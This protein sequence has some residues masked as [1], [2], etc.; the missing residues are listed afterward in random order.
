VLEVVDPGLLLT[1]QDR[2]RSGW[3]HLGIPVSGAADAWG[4]VAA[5]LLAG[6]PAEAAALEVTLGGAELIARE[7]CLIALGGADLGAERDDGLALSVGA[8]HR[9]PVGARLRFAGSR[10]GLRAYLALSGGVAANRVLGSA[11]TYATAALGGVDGRALSAGDV[12]TPMRRGDLAAA[13]ISWP[14][15]APPHPATAPGPILFVPGPD[16]RHLDVGVVGAFTAAT[17]RIGRTGDRMG[18]RLEGPPLAAGTEIVSHA[19]VPG[20]IQLPSGGQPLVLLVDGPT[21][22][23]YPVVGV[24]TRAEMPRLGQLRPGDIVRFGAQEPHGARA[25]WR[26]QQD[27]LARAARALAADSLWHRLA[28]HAGG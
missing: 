13:G 3:A 19:L 22:G 26:A 1:L 25:A 18:L 15:E 12:L 6:A 2:G 4:L 10:N 28:D 20:A 5:N 9:L 8:A 11:S 27:A 14:A 16:L 21:V 17:W 7:T 24:V 23:G